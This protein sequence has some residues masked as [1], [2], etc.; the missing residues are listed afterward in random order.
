[1]RA[2]DSLRYERKF[3]PEGLDRPA[4]ERWVRTH[5]AFFGSQYPPRHV[6]NVYLDTPGRLGYRQHVE[7]A[8]VRRKIR[9]RWY[10]EARGFVEGALELKTRRGTVVCKRSWRVA[11]LVID[12]SFD[13]STLLRGAAATLPPGLVRRL[14]CLEPVLVNRYL[15][16]YYRSADGAFRLTLDDDLSY[17]ALT[18]GPRFVR[19]RLVGRRGTIVELK[20]GP[21][22]D[23]RAGRIAAA[24]PFRVSRSSK[25]C[26]GLRAITP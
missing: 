7:G 15:R 10:G 8:D 24:F 4:V 3:R 14:W 17:A 23:A 20:Y 11:P 9:I 19:G 22:H 6:N 21:P 16:A 13:Y 12:E 25:Y 5:P 2:D 26:L 18:G 1:M